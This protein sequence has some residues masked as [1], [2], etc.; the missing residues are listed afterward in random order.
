MRP[1]LVHTGLV[2]KRMSRPLKNFEKY[3]R[4]EKLEYVAGRKYY[5]KWLNER[6]SVNDF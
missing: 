5:N 6:H 4:N 2:N 1:K 3:A